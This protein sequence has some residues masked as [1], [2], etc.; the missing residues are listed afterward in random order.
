MQ[1]FKKTKN[2]VEDLH[3]DLDE[4]QETVAQAELPEDVREFAT[5]ELSR[6]KN[7]SPGSAEYT[8]SRNHLQYLVELPWISMTQDNLDI[9][10]AQTIL[11][12]EH[13][14]LLEIKDRILEH[15]SV[16][17]LKHTR[18]A[19][20][21]IVDD[22]VKTCRALAH[23]LK[24]EGYGVGEAN[25]GEQALDMI[26]Q[27]RF[28]LVLTD[29]KMK[30]ID[31]LQLLQEAKRV[32]P[33]T[34]VI[35]MTGY[36]TVPVAVDAIQKGSYQFLSKPFQLEEVREVVAQALSRKKSKLDLQGPILCFLGPPGTGK[37]S[38]GLSI[39]RALER[40]FIRMSLAGVKDE[41]QLRGHRRSY[42]GSLPG[43][44]IQEIKRVGTKNPVFMLDEIDKLGQDFKGDPSAALLEILDP[45]QNSRFSDHYLEVPFDL[46]K[47]MFIVT[48]NTTDT[49]PAPLLDRLELI[50]LS[51]Y[52]IEEKERIAF[53]YLLPR[54]KAQAS[55]QEYDLQVTPEAV[56]KVIRGYTREA[57]LRGLQRQLA[58]ICRKTA[59]SILQNQTKPQE[60]IQ[61]TPEVVEDLLGLEQYSFEVAAAKDRIGVATG[62]AWTPYGGEIMFVEATM[63]PGNGKLIL[64]GSL[65]DVLKESAQ[66]ALSYVRSNTSLFK[67]A[68]DLFSS[69]DLHVHV[70]AGAIP[71]DGP[72][73]GLTI[74]V[75]LLS[76]LTGRPCKRDVAFSGEL[77]LSGRVLPV[78]GIR[79]KLLAAR[80]SGVSTV[81]FP[82][83]NEPDLKQ[84]PEYVLQELTV[85]CIQ[86]VQEILDKVL[87]EF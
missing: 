83:K 49:I 75:A 1:L 56:Q 6:M 32:D 67:V 11:D 81:V 14:G 5:K 47:V 35:I 16:R 12:Q 15:L 43:R 27:A 29:L 62:L 85:Y 48:A 36:A 2:E 21:L 34:E 60:V 58:S 69:R 40:K 54:E 87:I 46:S 13:F 39:A 64:T 33:D 26:L 38:L 76:L 74:A 73:A 61:I 71:K 77:T 82:F 28:D 22:E 20:I 41:S 42:V 59:R 25:S 63:M 55:L 50:R 19:Q 45:E 68:D 72:S 8:I 65:G 78:S 86:D 70:P 84:I 52:T 57:G 4:F 31:G 53:D 51:G 37:T 17:I 80:N 18:K 3:T 44:I 23:V 79:E 9:G 7:M 30:N 66:A 10:H 24:K